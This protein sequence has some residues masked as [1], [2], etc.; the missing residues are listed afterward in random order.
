MTSKIK[1]ESDLKSIDLIQTKDILL[2]LGRIK[3]KSQLLIGFA[4]ETDNE[5]I[6][7][8]KKIKS[9]NLNAIVLNSLKDK[10]AG[11]TFDTNKITFIKNNG[12]SKSFDLK[13][14]SDVAIDVMK[15]IIN[16]DE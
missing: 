5:I 14:K 4:L 2:E 7:A 1:K 13:S 3:K 15:E 9:K 11:F 16:I 12:K 10:N 6:N 8:Q